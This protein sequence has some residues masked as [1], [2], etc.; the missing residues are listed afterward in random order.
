[1]DAVEAR[2]SKTNVGI[3]LEAWS[4]AA[5]PGTVVGLGEGPEG[6]ACK[7]GVYGGLGASRGAKRGHF[8]LSRWPLVVSMANS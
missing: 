6:L 1:M 8:W 2:F 3:T 7:R 4:K 5:G